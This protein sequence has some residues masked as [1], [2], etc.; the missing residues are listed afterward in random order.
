MI[1]VTYAPM[2]S[3]LF[4]AALMRTNQLTQGEIEKYEMPQ[5]WA[6]TAMFRCVYAVL[7]QGAIVLIILALTN[8]SVI[9]L[10]RARPRSTRCRSLGPGHN[11]I[12]RVCHGHAV[13]YHVHGVGDCWT[14]NQFDSAWLVQARVQ[15]CWTRHSWTPPYCCGAHADLVSCSS[16]LTWLCRVRP[17]FCGV[18]TSWSSSVYVWHG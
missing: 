18:G 3:V 13:L 17:R 2:L 9:S 12:L 4:L 5:P 8:E 7:A 11:V 16:C 1:T 6:Q 15:Q 14:D 10:R